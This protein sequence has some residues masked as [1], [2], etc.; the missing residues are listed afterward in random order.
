MQNDKSQNKSE[1]NSKN[2]CSYALVIRHAERCDNSNLE[3]EL[4][5]IELKCDPPLTD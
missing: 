5:K 4:A 1:T 3:S 2:V